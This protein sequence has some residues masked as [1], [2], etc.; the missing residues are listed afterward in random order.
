[1]K[2]KSISNKYVRIGTLI[3]CLLVLLFIIPF[4]IPMST[5]L[6]AGNHIINNHIEEIY[7]SNSLSGHINDSFNWLNGTYIPYGEDKLFPLYGDKQ[8]GFYNLNNKTVMFIRPT[9]TAWFILMR[10]GNC[11]EHADYFYDVFKRIGY[12]VRKVHAAGGDHAI[13]Q[14]VENETFYFI[15]PSTPKILNHS[16]YFENGQWGRIIA[17]T[18]NGIELDL[19]NEIITNKTN[20]SLRQNTT[21][22]V[23]TA[24]KST[25]LMSPDCMYDDPKLVYQFKSKNESIVVSSGT[26]YLIENFRDFGLFKFS[27]EKDVDLSQNITIYSQDVP[28][29]FKTFKI[30]L[31][32]Y[33]IL[34]IAFIIGL[35][36]CI[37]WIIKII[38]NLFSR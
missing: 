17:I 7:T 23:K 32:G 13:I 25:F 21:Q 38:K 37:N 18:T 36:F 15:D 10:T 34:L 4:F 11:G 19:T 31:I 3:L 14:I 8:N 5:Q 16:T 20:V 35:Y 9:T 33:F 22:R 26:K 6:F 1:M 27:I 29:T 24:I 28:I 2:Q 12:D 30:T